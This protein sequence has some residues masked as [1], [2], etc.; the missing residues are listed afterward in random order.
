MLQQPPQG[1]LVVDVRT[2][3]RAVDGADVR[4]EAQETRTDVQG[5]ARLSLPPGTWSVTDSAEAFHN[6]TI[7]V[8]IDAGQETHVEVEL[9]PRITSEERVIVTAA[10]TERRLE[11]QPV[12]IEV[13][14]RDDI[15]EKALMTPGS[16]AMLLGETT[17][18][19]VQTTAP[20]LGAANVRIQGLR[21]HYS[22][23]LAD[24]LPLYG[25]QGDSFSLL[26]VPPL[27]LAQVE[28]IKGVASALYGASA[29]GGVVNLVSRRPHE[30]ERQLLVNATSQTGRDVAAW[31]A[32][33]PS[34]AWSW[35]LLGSFNGQ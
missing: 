12:R 13:I 35:T 3:G 9:T 27:D 17:G 26:Q 4:A 11:D 34:G 28:V 33:T 10:R 24:G 25:A 8:R 30:N 2:A 32:K 29:L 1:V 18:L 15:E 5:R 20:S 31:F 16:V 14:D 23:L 22:Q 6:A 21:G 7:N 19:R